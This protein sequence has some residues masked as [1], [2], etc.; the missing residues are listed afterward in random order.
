MILRNS[1]FAKRGFGKE[2]KY[3]KLE[4]E[5]EIWSDQEKFHLSRL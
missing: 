1:K 4:L 5:R 2:T 3:E